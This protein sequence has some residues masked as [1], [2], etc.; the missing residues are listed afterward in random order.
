MSEQDNEV[1]SVAEDAEVVIDMDKETRNWAMFL[2]FSLLAGF[3][4]PLAG[5]VAPIVIWLMKKED[6]PALDV[7]GKVVMNWIVSLLIYCLVCFALMFILIGIPM[8]WVLGL[9]AI[10]FP[11]IGGI[12]AND[13]VLWRYPL[14]L[15]IF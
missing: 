10:I 3:V 12:K 1:G 2:H 13:G 9:L 11:I 5:L 8:M 6:M 4:I 15:K 14:S 7:H